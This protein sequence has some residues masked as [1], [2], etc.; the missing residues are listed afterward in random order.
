MLDGVDVASGADKDS[1]ASIVFDPCPKQ[2]VSVKWR[3]P[4]VSQGKAAGH[5]PRLLRQPL[6]RSHHLIE[7]PGYDSAVNKPGR[8][9][10]KAVETNSAIDRGPPVVKLALAERHGWG[11]CVQRP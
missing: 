3:R 10:T 7:E 9:F 6:R 8:T 2:Q 11:G 5:G 4:T 1:S